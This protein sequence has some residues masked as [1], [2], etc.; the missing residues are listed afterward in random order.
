M[1]YKLIATDMDGTLLNTSGEVSTENKEALEKADQIGVKIVLSTGRLYK[2][3]HY[4]SIKLGLNHPIISSN[5]AL[6]HDIDGN[7][8]YENLLSDEKLD[9]VLNKLEEYDIY[10]HL[11]TT[12]SVYSKTLNMDM[13]KKYYGDNNGNL[14]V[15][16]VKFEDYKDILFK[17]NKFNKL[18]C[19]DTDGEKLRNLKGDLGKIK[20]IE[21]TS[22]WINNIEIMNENVSKKTAVEYLCNK[23][24][25]NSKDIFAI[26]DNGNDLEMIEFAGLGIAMG[27]AIEEVK[28]T[29]NY[30][31]DT[32][33]N[34]G[35]AKAIEKFIL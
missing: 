20:G 4:H 14:I 26:G 19:I 35:L 33:D 32:N 30:I 11:Y 23:Y 5:G 7:V 1:K 6:I 28:R 21:L 34:D 31:T 12:D 17:G 24:N 18:V 13:L 27:N 22:S 3:A 9:K 10:Y 16:A 25:M 15:E 2:S 29:A 8:V